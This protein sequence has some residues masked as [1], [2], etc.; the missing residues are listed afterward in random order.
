MTPIAP[1]TILNRSIILSDESVVSI[2]ITEL[3]N[4]TKSF[5]LYDGRPMEVTTG[6]TIKIRKSNYIT[7]IV[8]LNWRS[9]I[10]NIRDNV[11]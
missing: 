11:K 7:K 2:K 10:D 1:H 8:K 4:D 9:F 3:R 5:V 6:D